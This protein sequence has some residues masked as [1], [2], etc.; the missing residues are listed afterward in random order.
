MK[1]NCFLKVDNL[2]LIGQGAS[3]KVFLHPC[4]DGKIIKLMRPEVVA[5]DGGFSSHSK[6]KRKMFQG[7]YRQFRREVIQ[8]LQLCKN[9]YKKNNFTFPVEIPYGFI[10]TDQGLGLVVEKITG[11]SGKG[12]TVSDLCKSGNFTEK[13]RKALRKFFDDCCA[14]H[15]VFGEVNPAGIMY[16]ESRRGFPEFVLVDGMGEKLFIPLRAMSQRINARYVR[17]V[18]ARIK[19]KLGICY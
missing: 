8:Y 11:P 10:E 3:K 7:V 5:D 14:M 4:E 9:D 16:T 12:E 2:F 1:N 15:I 18:E 13:H 17:K 6:L 19:Q